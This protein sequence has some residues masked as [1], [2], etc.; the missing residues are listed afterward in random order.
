VDAGLRISEACSIKCKNFDFKIEI[1]PSISKKESKT[2]AN[3]SNIKPAS[4]YR[5]IFK[6][7]DISIESNSI[8]FLLK[9]LLGHISRTMWEAINLISKNKYSCIASARLTAFVCNASSF[10]RFIPLRLKPCL[11]IKIL[12]PLIYAEIPTEDCETV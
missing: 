2:L 7:N 12:I 11:D 3:Y 8:Y 9:H 4:S 6:T 5:G 1:S 10:C